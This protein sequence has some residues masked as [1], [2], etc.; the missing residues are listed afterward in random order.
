[1]LSRSN[2]NAGDRLQRAKS[3]SS[4]HTPSS[5]H[6][7]TTTSIDPF[8][9]R[10]QAEAAAVEAFHRARPYQD[11][12]FQD[13][14]P[15]PP[16]PQR[17]RSRVSGRAEGG[18]FEEAR[19]ERQ[20][21]TSTKDNSANLRPL[22]A[23]PLQSDSTKK[24]NEEVSTVTRKRPVIPPNTNKS[25]S[26]Y[27]QSS[28]LPS[29]SRH[30]KKSQSDYTDGSPVPRHSSVLKERASTLQLRTPQPER[31]QGQS[32]SIGLGP[33][34]HG[35]E[36]FSYEESQ[37]PKG[38]IRETQTDAEILAIARDR[39]LQDFQQKKL[40]ERKSFILA[41]FQKR[42]ATNIQK[43]SKSSYD[44]SLPPFN[45]AQS[46]MPPPPSQPIE[47]APEAP[48]IPPRPEHKTRNFSDTLKGRF[49]KVFRKTSRAPSGMPA[50]HVEGKTFHF[51]ISPPLST[52]PT[53]TEAES[54]PFV[55]ADHNGHLP[56]P[57]IR[58]DS[59]SSRR[60]GGAQ[61][62]AKSRVTSWTN[63]T[64]AG[65]WS[66]RNDIEHQD[67]AD[68][69]GRLKRS[70]SVSTLRKARSF[71]G[72]PIQN[73]LRKPSKAQLQSSEES[74]G[75][76]SALKERIEPSDSA[77]Q[78]ANQGDSVGSRTS[79]AL[80]TLPSQQRTSSA[81]GSN[82]RRAP[83]T[84][85]SV[86]PDP[87]AYKLDNL[88]PVTEVMSPDPS[89]PSGDRSRME[90]EGSEP[91][92]RSQLQRRPALKAPTPSKEQ[93]ERRLE[94]SKNRWQSPLDELSPSPQMPTK[95][96]KMDDNPYELRSLSRTLQQPIG[97][98]DLPHHARVGEQAH[99][100]RQNILS[101]SVYSRGTDGA[102][103]RPSTPVDHG[104]MMITITGREVRSYS[105]SPPKRRQPAERPVQASHDWRRWLSIEMNGWVG[106]SAPEDFKLPRAILKDS[107][108]A[109]A[110]GVEHEN[111]GEASVASAG[112]H[113]AVPTMDVV[114]VGTTARRR[115]DSRSSSLMNEQ[116]PLMDTGRDFSNGHKVL[117]GSPS[118]RCSTEQCRQPAV[119]RDNTPLVEDERPR[120][121]ITRPRIVTQHQ[122]LAHLRSAANQQPALS[123]ECKAQPALKENNAF[124]QPGTFGGT[125][126]AD[127]TNKAKLAYK[128]KSAFDIRANYK[129][130]STGKPKPI[131]VRR[132]T[133]HT[134]SVDI[135]EDTTIQNIS[136]GPYALPSPSTNH[137][138]TN[139]EN[140][141]PSE[142]NSLPVLSSSEWL[143]AG[144][145]KKRDAKKVSNMHPAHRDRSAS[146]Y[147]PSRT[148]AATVTGG[149]TSP[150]QRLF[151]T[152]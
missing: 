146:R 151:Q 84:I 115:R 140:T 77:S 127:L 89:L 26:Q 52:P 120:S 11:T 61:S 129:D 4:A 75:L 40:R 111:P 98:I 6:H 53:A 108:A 24:T 81:A 14:R 65:T 142:A 101:P 131:A 49:K 12:A 54:D 74:A 149:G 17:R 44:T 18:H 109:R 33:S 3:T 110:E 100:A 93:I 32:S 28:S 37:T 134:D 139:K 105:I 56:M 126:G 133:G 79:S 72:R 9:T 38:S 29:S 46:G 39:C 71:F 10:Q 96:S 58:A 92:P 30:T 91:T 5:G 90:D 7:H 67:V 107:Q 59:A 47:T 34:L 125:T 60:S 136:A 118:R 143:A 20:R 80:A 112:S 94:R 2:S 83:L 15:V 78:E 95:T 85:R 41:P 45:Y 135:L 55:V 86:T 68:E 23:R 103:T 27:D 66:T 35:Q 64:V 36:A 138:G 63:S 73:R 99:S 104:G 150:G 144:T 43:S 132:R 70:N 97:T 87:A 147:S 141:P 62:T 51:S 119:V 117:S 145:T 121:V 8:V 76:Y 16:K 152:A 69:Q 148:G 13:Y 123:S 25:A 22:R 106:G 116:Y 114:R 122:S 50:Q 88:T 19:L 130:S 42:R 57:D 48:I 21:S 102:S 1:M 124:A 82:S 128:P 137:A 31:S 113:S